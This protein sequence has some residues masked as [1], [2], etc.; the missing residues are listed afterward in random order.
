MTTGNFHSGPLCILVSFGVP[1]LL[2]LLAITISATV[3]HWRIHFLPWH[4]EWL[5]LV[6]LILLA[7][8]VH[9]VLGFWLIYG[10]LG[11]VMLQFFSMLTFM[12]MLAATRD[13]EVDL[14]NYAH[15]EPP[16]LLEEPVRTRVIRFT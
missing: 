3:K 13:E 2:L 12:E 4:D 8:I 5:R 6:H 7:Y 16:K 9:L 15:V 14:K 11:M 1:G 10:D